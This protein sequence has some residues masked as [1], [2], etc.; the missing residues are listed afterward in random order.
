M[1]VS[2]AMTAV[3]AVAPLHQVRAPMTAPA[4]VATVRMSRVRT[5]NNGGGEPPLVFVTGVSLVADLWLETELGRV[6]ADFGE[7]PLE[8]C[9]SAST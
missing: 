1:A 8:L 2:A 4:R 7:F 9:I 6:D 5:V 3:G